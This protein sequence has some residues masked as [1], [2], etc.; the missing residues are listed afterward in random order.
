MDEERVGLNR[1]RF[2][3]CLSVMGLGGTLL[4]DALVI[5]AQDS[6]TV[7]VEMIEA[8]QKIAGVSFTR[9]EQLAIV[10]RIN[11]TRGYMAGF[12]FL[13]TVNLGNSAQPAIVFNPVPPGKVLPSGPRFLRR[14]VPVVKRPAT[15]EALAFLPVTHLAK[16]IE[17]RQVKPSELTELYLSRLAK[18]DPTLHCVVSFTT[19]LARAQ[20]RQADDEIAAGRYRGPLHGIPFGLK[21]LFAVK[22]TKTTW[23]ASPFKDQV[24]DADAT[25]YL[26]LRDAGAILVAKLSTGALALSAQWFGGSFAILLETKIIFIAR[27]SLIFMSV[28]NTIY[29]Q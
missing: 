19:E 6:D 20:A 5:A 2:F 14:S 12:A 25:V 23:G 13:R 24:I 4:P 10:T 22:G 9:Q 8:A 17:S 7:T 3:E 18:Y 21:D 27:Y 29:I 16:L 15:D 1:R 28:F 26:K 11:A